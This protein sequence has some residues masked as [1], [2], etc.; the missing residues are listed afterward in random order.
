MFM[1][2]WVVI[3]RFKYNYTNKIK[4]IKWKSF[5]NLR[6]SHVKNPSNFPFLIYI[7]FIESQSASRYKQIIVFPLLLGKFKS[8]NNS[9]SV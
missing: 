9:F 4:S 5:Q 3:E 8:F 2:T 1:Q 7:N 6:N